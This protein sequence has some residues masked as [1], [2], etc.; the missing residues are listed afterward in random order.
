MG[1]PPKA[2]TFRLDVGF[3][4]KGTRSMKKFLIESKTFFISPKMT[5]PKT[6]TYTNLKS[7]PLEDHKKG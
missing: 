7:R 2:P 4:N 3:L 5:P 1:S 6:K